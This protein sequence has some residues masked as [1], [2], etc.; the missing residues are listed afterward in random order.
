MNQRFPR[1]LSPM[2]GWVGTY[3]VGFSLILLILILVILSLQPPE[4]GMEAIGAGI[5]VVVAGA[6]L[7]N[8]G[9]GGVLIIA[10]FLLRRS[11]LSSG[12]RRR[13]IAGFCLAVVLY[14]AT[15][16]GSMVGVIFLA[17]NWQSWYLGWKMPQVN[18]GDSREQVEQTIGRGNSQWECNSK[19]AKDYSLATDLSSCAMVSIYLYESSATRS[20]W[21]VAYGKDDRVVAKYNAVAIYRNGQLVPTR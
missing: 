14:L 10:S 4:T 18:L 12:W 1:W 3:F 2:L 11:S 21:E 15:G 19:Y 7:L 13:A 9:L 5:Y 6:A 8:L 20:Q 17:E 16:L